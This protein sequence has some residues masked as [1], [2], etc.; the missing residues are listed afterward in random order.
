ML[1]DSDEFKSSGTSKILREK[2]SRFFLGRAA[3]ELHELVGVID[4]SHRHSDDFEKDFILESSQVFYWLALAA[5]VDKRNFEEF[6]EELKA[7]LVELEK[8][9]ETNGIEF[10]KVFEKDLR[11]CEKKGYL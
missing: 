1:R 4:G 8:F 5:V 3:E 6:E 7:K 9:H 11:E 2:N 10:K